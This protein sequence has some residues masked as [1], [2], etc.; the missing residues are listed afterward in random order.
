MR[1]PLLAILLLLGTHGAV[2]EPIERSRIEVIDGG[3]VRTDGQTVRLV[4]FDAPETG[5]DMARCDAGGIGRALG[6]QRGGDPFTLV[7][8]FPIKLDLEQGGSRLDLP[9]F[10][11]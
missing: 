2:A 11:G 7:V 3:T 1:L 9:C 5:D 10:R 4:G 8:L 6:A